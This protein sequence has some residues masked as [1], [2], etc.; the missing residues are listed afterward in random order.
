MRELTQEYLHECFRYNHALGVLIWKERPI[1]H[2]NTKHGWKVFNSLYAGKIAGCKHFCKSVNGYYWHIRLDG[3]LLKRSRLVFIYQGGEIPTGFVIDHISGDTLDD[4]LNNLRKVT[5]QVNSYNVKKRKSNNSG[6]TGVCW[7]KAN[8]KWMSQARVKGKTKKLY[9]GDDFF[10]AV[11]ARK[12][13]E[14]K[15]LNITKRHGK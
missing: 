10:E 8:K 1:N 3:T 9:Y 12:S 13:W 6:V 15:N 11:C 2:F 7:N 5:H 14:L 4:K